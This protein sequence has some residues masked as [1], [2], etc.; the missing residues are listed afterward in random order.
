MKHGMMEVM[1]QKKMAPT[2]SSSL[3]YSERNVCD[4]DN[5]VILMTSKTVRN[6]GRSFGGA[7]TGIGNHHVN[8]LVA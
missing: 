4:C 8:F 6:P 5:D 2:K 3:F 1:A 7:Q